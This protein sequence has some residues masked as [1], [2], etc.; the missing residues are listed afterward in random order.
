MARPAYSWTKLDTHRKCPHAYRK[1]YLDKTPRA[2]YEARDTGLKAHDKVARYLV[3]LIKTDQPTDFS[4]AQALV[5]PDDSLDLQEIWQTFF[6]RFIKPDSWQDPRV[7]QKL[8]F[9]R[10][11]QRVDWFADDTFFR[12]VVDLHYLE[13]S[14]A[15]VKDW[16]TNRA[17]PKELEKDLQ[18]RIYG[19]GVRRVYYPDAE[20]LLLVLHYLRYGAERKILL[21]P[22]DLDE[23]PRFIEEEVAKI[24]K[25]RKMLPTPGSFCGM[26]GVAHHCPEMQGALTQ[27]ILATPTTPEEAVQVATKFLALE[28]VMKELKDRLRAYINEQGPVIVNDLVYGA[29]V[30]ERYDL[31]PEAIATMAME[32]GLS[33]EDAWKLL[34]TSKSLIE[35]NLRKMKKR[36]FLEDFLATTS[37]KID[38][39]I[40]FGKLKTWEQKQGEVVGEGQ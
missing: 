15:V 30:S 17:V 18:T 9:D 32:K 31:N 3:H 34:N 36:E 1:I 37:P 40:K 24:E 16:K 33:R 38:T 26:C 10:N 2:Q 13:E 25:D 11:W 22:E 19:W 27:E 28:L 21:D 6:T 23:V 35:T 4:M 8:A 39:T 5:H 14:L 7:E 20:E 12:M 29:W